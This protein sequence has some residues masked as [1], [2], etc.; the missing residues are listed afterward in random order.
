M[1][2]S[3][4]STLEDALDQYSDNLLWEG[5]ATKALNALEAIRWLLINRSKVQEK[6]GIKR[7]FESL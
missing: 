3:S 5:N 4:A 7:D 6:D 1:V 2:L